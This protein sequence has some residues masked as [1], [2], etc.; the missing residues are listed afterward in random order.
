MSCSRSSSSRSPISPEST[1]CP[2]SL[3]S[4]R[5][6]TTVLFSQFEVAHSA[7]NIRD[8]FFGL[9][10]SLDQALSPCWCHDG[11]LTLARWPFNWRDLGDGGPIWAP[12]FR[13]SLTRSGCPVQGY[14]WGVAQAF[15]DAVRF[16][17]LSLGGAKSRVSRESNLRYAKTEI[18]SVALAMTASAPRDRMLTLLHKN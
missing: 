6:V 8:D 18:A 9:D 5:G 12:I 1:K 2:K 14:F 7:S 15:T 16:A 13:Y 4:P 10:Y 17:L 11:R 3:S